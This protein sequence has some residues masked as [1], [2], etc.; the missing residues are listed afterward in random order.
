LIQRDITRCVRCYAPKQ[1]CACCTAAYPNTAFTERTH[2][3]SQSGTCLA[4]Y[5]VGMHGMHVLLEAAKDHA[6][7]HVLLEAAN[8]QANSTGKFLCESQCYR[9]NRDCL[10]E[11]YPDQ[12]LLRPQSPCRPTGNNTGF[13][14][15]C[16]V[17]EAGPLLDHIA[18]HSAAGKPCHDANLLWHQSKRLAPTASNIN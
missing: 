13:T 8:R 5:A 12:R 14:H 6:L 7:R 18:M 2:R 1:H 17:I 16:C 9:C 4:A 11:P 3:H 10:I 15:C